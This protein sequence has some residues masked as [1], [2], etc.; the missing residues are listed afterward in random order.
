MAVYQ[1][2]IEQAQTLHHPQ[3]DDATVHFSSW[4]AT[5]RRALLIARL[6]SSLMIRSGHS[7][8]TCPAGCAQAILA[9]KVRG[10]PGGRPKLVPMVH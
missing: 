5:Q 6:L 1:S 4:Q 3:W 8:Q 10:A 9:Q 2:C 7:T